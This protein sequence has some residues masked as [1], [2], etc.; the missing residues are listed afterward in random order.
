MEAQPESAPMTSEPGGKT[1]V[2]DLPK[3]RRGRV[4]S[5][6]IYEMSEDELEILESGSKSE[7]LLN[8]FVSAA[9]TAASF[10]ATLSTVDL[11][12]KPIT[13]TVFIVIA[14]VG[15]FSSIILLVLWLRAKNDRIEVVN[16]IR[17]RI[18]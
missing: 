6:S 18:K 16:R 13:R 10:L 12:D 7:A 5:V 8:L 3:I 4:Q 11:T 1:G 2:D 14:V 9:T 15:T 17:N